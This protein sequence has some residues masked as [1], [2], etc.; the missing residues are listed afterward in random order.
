MFVYCADEV[1]V[2]K[3]SNFFIFGGITVPDYAISEL[4]DKV[5]ETKKNFYKFPL[6]RDVEIKWNLRETNKQLKKSVNQTIT[7]QEH[8]K[9]KENIL[10]VAKRG[11]DDLGIFLCAV[12]Y[13]FFINDGWRCYYMAMNV[14][15]GRFEDYLRTKKDF[16]IVLIDEITSVKGK[17]EKGMRV[18]LTKEELREYLLDYVLS[19]YESGTGKKAVSQIPLIIPNVISTLSGLHQI[20]DIVLGAFQYYLRYAFRKGKE[21]DIAVQTVKKFLR[22]FHVNF[23]GPDKIAA[24]NCGINIYPQKINENWSPKL[25]KSFELCIKLKEALKGDFKIL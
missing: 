17:N 23:E 6:P 19:L 22:N 5:D 7:S 10:E 8:K 11:R 18:D 2:E 25:K 24:L 16:G 15:F 1:G 4:V 20:N 14:C 21:R 3:T 13:Q 12:P 9:L